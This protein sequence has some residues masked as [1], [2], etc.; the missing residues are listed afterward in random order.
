MNRIAFFLLAIFSVSSNDGL[1]QT[2]GNSAAAGLTNAQRFSQVLKARNQLAAQR[3]ATEFTAS[4]SSSTAGQLFQIASEYSTGVGP[5]SPAIA[6]FNGDGKLDVAVANYTDNTVSLLLGKGDGTF[7]QQ[8]SFATGIQPVSVDVRARSAG[9]GWPKPGS[10][11]PIENN[12][13]RLE[14]YVSRMSLARRS[15]V[16]YREGCG[17]ER[18]AKLADLRSH[19]LRHPAV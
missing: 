16:V 6:D 9:S 5:I 13:A 4:A 12:T 10:A 18:A 1:G 19:D 8:V 17:P 2:P 3:Q 15:P 7:Q 14:E 11:I